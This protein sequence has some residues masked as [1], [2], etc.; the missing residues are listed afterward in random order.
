V[1]KKPKKRGQVWISAVLYVLIIVVAIT[2]ILSTGLPILEKMKDKT[3]FTQAKN[4]LL[5]LD[6]YFQRI[7]DEGQGSQRVVPV[8]IRK[9]NLA[10]EGDK[11]LWQL[12]TEAEIL[13]PR[14]SIDIG[15][16]KISSNSDVDTT[17]TDSHYI[18]EN[19]KIRANISKCSSCPANQ[20]IESLYFKDTS[21]LLAGNFSFDLDGQ[22][23]TVNYTMM[24]PEGNNTN[25]GSA[26]VTAYLINQTQDL[27]L[28]LEGGADFIKINLE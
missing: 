7:K 23:L 19:S 18:L 8:E 10:I 25:I 5:N 27:L 11:L 28:T 20:L 3:V 1:V 21:T 16:I 12:E 24:V 13:Q 14:S 17:E 9:G 15:N 22:D 26:T 4:T 6:Q 2:I